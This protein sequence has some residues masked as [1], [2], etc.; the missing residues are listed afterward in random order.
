MP[1]VLSLVGAG[2]AATPTASIKW[3]NDLVALQRKAIDA[4]AVKVEQAADVAFLSKKR[5][6]LNRCQE[7][8]QRA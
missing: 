6:S 2:T 5:N 3:N 7:W 8:Y 4:N 1:T